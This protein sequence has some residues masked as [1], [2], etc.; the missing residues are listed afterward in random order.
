VGALVAEGIDVTDD[1][2][3]FRALADNLPDVVY[4]YR[5]IPAPCF[6]YVSPAVTAITGY[7]PEEHYADPAL[8]LR[9]VHPEDR[10]LYEAA[11][12]SLR[13]F[14]EPLLIRYVRKDGTVLWVEQRNFPVMDADGR[15]VAAGGIVR[16]V[17]EQVQARKALAE[18]EERHRQLFA[19]SPLPMWV[20]DPVSLRFLEVN[21]AAVRQYGYSREE[22]LELTVADIRPPEESGA[23]RAD[24]RVG[25]PSYGE[26]RHRTKDGGTIDVAVFARDIGFRD[27]PARLALVQDITDRRRAEREARESYEAMRRGDE[28]RR[29]LLDRTVRAV[30]EERARVAVELHDGPI[31]RLAALG[32]RL[33]RLARRLQDRDLDEARTDLAGVSRAVAAEIGELR[34]MMSDMRPPVLSER[35]L[36][37]ALRDHAMVVS[38]ESGLA[39][40][41]DI[42]GAGRADPTVETVLYRVAQE[43]LSNVVKH[44]RARRARIE[45][46][47][48]GGLL[49]LEI[50]DD[51]VGFRA[52]EMSGENAG[53]YLG[54]IGMRERVEM[55]GGTWNLDT[56]PGGG[57]MVRVVVPAAQPELAVPG[58]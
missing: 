9:F 15:L 50:G 41:V 43:A 14:A 36:G 54:V 52:P 33:E 13:A 49:T 1:R 6:E 27:R 29:W 31:Q 16:D 51:G 26:W 28:R 10:A 22:F 7:T 21:D 42:K 30:E 25:S 18:S 57:T 17:T 34:R 44:A 40:S 38:M 32:L 4:R 5:L 56:E 53:L 37:P 3:W 12:G 46:R 8:P 23:V 35:G 11:W 45:L 24:V 20:F 47:T 19:A 2:E 58:R 55:A 48:E 39:V